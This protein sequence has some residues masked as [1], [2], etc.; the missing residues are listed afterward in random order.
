MKE[1]GKSRIL[2]SS[3]AAASRHNLLQAL[4]STSIVGMR[5]L[6][7]TALCSRDAGT[8]GC[9]DDPCSPRCVERAPSGAA[10]NGP[11]SFD[12]GGMLAMRS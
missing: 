3:P 12:L 5:Q 6:P 11:V 9:P 2:K 1:T 10:A 7:S 8:S 4:L